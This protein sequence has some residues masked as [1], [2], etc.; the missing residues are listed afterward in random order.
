MKKALLALLAILALGGV[1]FAESPFDGIWEFH[2][3]GT[4]GGYE[5]DTS[6]WWSIEVH[7]HGDAFSVTMN[8]REE[9][10]TPQQPNGGEGHFSGSLATIEGNTLTVREYTFTLTSATTMTATAIIPEEVGGETPR[11]MAYTA[12]RTDPTPAYPTPTTAPAS[13]ASSGGGG[14]SFGFGFFPLLLAPLFLL[15]K[16]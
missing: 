11:D 9:F 5:V 7:D 13:S 12:T 14:C 6:G 10:S 16:R 15:L 8:Y 3:E 1:A 4:I 2:G